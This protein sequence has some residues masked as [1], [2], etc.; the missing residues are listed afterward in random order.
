ML[1]IMKAK[2]ALA[3]GDGLQQKAL[4]AETVGDS[5]GKAPGAVAAAAAAAAAPGAVAAAAAAAAAGAVPGS[6]AR[7]GEKGAGWELVGVNGKQDKDQV[8]A[9]RAAIAADIMQGGLCLLPPIFRQVHI[10]A[11]VAVFVGMCV[12]VFVCVCVCRKWMLA[13]VLCWHW[14]V[15]P[16]SC[17][18]AKIFQQF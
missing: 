14:P 5:G 10:C 3:R 12:C 1:A 11:R 7:G 17:S 18:C 16:A 8:R 6:A 13:C 4:V 9:K 2:R 15:L